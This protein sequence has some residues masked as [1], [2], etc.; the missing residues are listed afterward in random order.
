MFAGSGIGSLLLGIAVQIITSNEARMVTLR[1]LPQHACSELHSSYHMASF[2]GRD[3]ATGGRYRLWC[4]SAQSRKL[5][6]K[7]TLVTELA[8]QI[9]R[10]S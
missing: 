9:S 5:K 2:R 6:G 1:V 4:G 10:A 7:T 8:Q 3:P